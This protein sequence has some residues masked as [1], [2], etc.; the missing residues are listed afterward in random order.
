MSARRRDIEDLRR[1]MTMRD[2]R[3]QLSLAEM[4]ARHDALAE[5]NDALTAEVAQL[6]GALVEKDVVTTDDIAKAM[7]VDADQ[8][9]AAP[10]E[11]LPVEA[12]PVVSEKAKA[13]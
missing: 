4:Q 1:L 11:A 7:P 10:I 13:P 8:I 12:E 2:R 5:Q 9:K 6:R 3:T